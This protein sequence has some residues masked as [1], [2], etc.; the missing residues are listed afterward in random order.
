MSVFAE[1]L[2]N[3]CV[4]LSLQRG[5]YQFNIVSEDYRKEFL[6]ATAYERE[7]KLMEPPALSIAVLRLSDN[8]KGYKIILDDAFY[9][10]IGYG[11]WSEELQLDEGRYTVICPRLNKEVGRGTLSIRQL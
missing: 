3:P 6:S 5:R 11:F 1:F 7:E 8:D 10:P 4:Q 9:V 2:K